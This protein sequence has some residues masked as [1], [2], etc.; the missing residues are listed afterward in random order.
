[1]KCDHCGNEIQTGKFRQ[2]TGG[3]HD[4]VKDTTPLP[5]ICNRCGGSFC[6]KCRLPENHDCPALPISGRG[7]GWKMPGEN[8]IIQ[9][10]GPPPKSTPNIK[11]YIFM[12]LAAVLF[13][14]SIYIS[15]SI[16]Q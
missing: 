4:V 10:P 3:L 8:I 2:Y 12:L 1:M 5:F 7:G 9:K 11:P 14:I 15:I 13:L 16:L 6:T